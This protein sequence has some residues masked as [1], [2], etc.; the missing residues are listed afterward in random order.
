MK[1]RFSIVISAC[2]LLLLSASLADA[3]ETDLTMRHA[4][5]FTGT[6]TVQID[7]KN[8][9]YATETKGMSLKKSEA[10]SCQG[11]QCTFNLGFI[12]VRKPANGVLKPF[13]G[14][15]TN[16]TGDHLGNSVNFSDKESIR[17]GVLPLKLAIGKNQVT[18]QLDPANKIPQ[19]DESN[20]TFS[21]WSTVEP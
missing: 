11:D 6:K 18:V 8:D 5:Y 2:A 1:F 13:V 3:Q 7:L 15:K 21:V 12:V 17:Q 10:T 20:N 9:R 19:T 4:L 16:V 14:L